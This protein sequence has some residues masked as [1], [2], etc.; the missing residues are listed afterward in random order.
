[1]SKEISE[2]KGVSETLL[3]PLVARYRETKSDHGI[4]SDEESVRVLDSLGLDASKVS[5]SPIDSAGACLRTLIIDDFVN[6]FIRD[7]PEGI[8]VNCGCGLDTRFSR[9][10]NGRIRWFDIDLP[11]V[12]ELRKR[13]FEEIPRRCFISGSVLESEWIKAIP[14]AGKT[15]FV[16]E[17]LLI[18][19]SEEEV[20][21]FFLNIKDHFPDAEL[22]IHTFSAF[23]VRASKFT[24]G[25]G[26][27]RKKAVDMVQWG[28]ASGLEI[29]EWFPG[30]AL[31]EETNVVDRDRSRFPLAFRILWRIFPGLANMS[32]I[33]HLRMS[34]IS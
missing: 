29:E 11:N 30:I 17:G 3:I 8:I 15:L 27:L 21:R 1:M 25:R 6:R 5:Q 24:A 16:M 18:Y 13:V 14:K 12:I 33:I 34:G 9:L 22:V 20:K 31:V 2:L 4:L 26:G 10:D 19:F 23:M 7:N 32:K 28:I